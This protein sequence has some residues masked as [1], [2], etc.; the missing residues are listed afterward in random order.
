MEIARRAGVPVV[1][2]TCGLNLDDGRRDLRVSPPL[3]PH[4]PALR[5]RIVD[6][7]EGLIREQPWAFTLWPAM[8]AFFRTDAHTGPDVAATP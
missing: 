2:F 6:Y 3:D 7:W 1:I 5:Q 8:P 4:D